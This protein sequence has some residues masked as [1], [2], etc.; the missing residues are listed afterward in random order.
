[1]ET[2]EFR[3]L[4]ATITVTTAADELHASNGQVSLREAITA[5]NAGNDLGDT[6]I[7][8]QNPGAFGTGDTI[9][10]N[11]PGS[12]PHT[13]DIGADSTASGLA[14]P[15]LTK[16]MVIDA[17]TQPGFDSTTHAPIIELNGT[18][19]PQNSSGVAFDIE[20]GSSTIRGFV[21]NRFAG[22]AA[23]LMQ[24][25]GG[26]LIA[27]NYVGTNSAG[28]AASANQA[29][30][31]LIDV[32]SNGNT[33]GGTSA[34]D[35][36]V[37]SGNVQNG[38][39][40]EGQ[41]NDNTLQGNLIGTDATGAF[42]IPNMNGIDI[43][44]QSLRTTIGGTAAG[45]G[46]LI[47]GNSQWGAAILGDTSGSDIIQ[48]NFIGTDITG[49][50]KLGNGDIGLICGGTGSLVGGTDPAARN[51]I[52][53]NGADGLELGYEA[54]NMTVQGN[55]IGTD[56]TGTKPIGNTKNG[57]LVY[58]SDDDIIGG[59]IPEAANVIA[60]NGQNGVE[61]FNI[62]NEDLIRLNSIF[63][64][65]GL[66]IKFGTDPGVTPNDPNDPDTG[67]NDLQNFPVLG[68]AVSNSSGTTI[69]GSLN[70]ISDTLF[71]ID[72]YAN[73]SVDPSLNGEGQTYLGSVTVT[74]DSSGNANFN[75]TVPVAS[76][77]G[78]YLSAT[79][80][81]M[82]Q[83]PFGQTSEFSQDI[84]ITA[85]PDKPLQLI[86]TSPV[87][88]VEG[89]SFSATLA[90]FSDFDVQSIP[91]DFTATIDWGDGSPT[92]PG[93]IKP[94]AAGGFDVAGGHTYAEEGSNT[95]T[96]TIK[97]TTGRDDAGGASLV[98]TTLA[99]IADAPIHAT[100]K[101]ISANEGRLFAGTV[102]T[103]TD[104]NLSAPLGDFTATINWG[105]GKTTTGS[106]FQSSPG[107]FFVTGGHAYAE[108]GKYTA[109]T[110]IEDV[111]GSTASASSSANIGESPLDQGTG[112]SLT[113]S[114]N[115]T[116]TNLTIATFRD[117]D[118]LNTLPGDYSGTINWGD[119]KTSSVKFAFNGSTF[120]VGSF[121]KV[122]GSHKY[123]SKKTFT[124]KITLL[125][126]ANPGAKLN[127]TSTIK[128]A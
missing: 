120:N 16:P 14:L 125:D 39:E 63:S 12:G 18:S 31:I 72:F 71:A 11:I 127:I 9:K 29:D 10:F 23:I 68:S 8:A 110:T 102:A 36:N 44:G 17:T 112:K 77:A 53:G 69:Q 86:G 79:A 59:P 25:N 41:S 92:S 100:A 107:H 90:H 95:V 124:V 67:L 54:G 123:T 50:E 118:S 20:A 46:N 62:A 26:N 49:T 74:T 33:I 24:H 64:N 101:T 91:A 37:V 109:K 35:G 128:A 57:V 30:G 66:G 42:A 82:S 75:T 113:V 52:S 115:A 93:V 22:S 88:S 80:T 117:Q 111:G 96:I 58:R 105:D 60:F 104:E 99:N 98:A 13:I 81:D 43:S 45:A 21:I 4:L 78:K 97:D 87:S 34:G 48:G 108:A 121:W 27:G 76:L 73:D 47:S 15:F 6:D 119:G 7:Q 116:F 103:F 61:L 55:Y 19:G 38:I 122:Q 70:T 2:L 84:K 94:N 106:V 3:R 51:I 56:V 83:S 40:I 5:I 85:P 65:G 32:T 89:K 1:V 28:S 114:A 126:T